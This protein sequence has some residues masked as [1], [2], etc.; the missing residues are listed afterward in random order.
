MSH[1]SVK[2]IA[3]N[4]RGQGHIQHFQNALF[5]QRASMSVLVS[6]ELTNN[7]IKYRNIINIVIRGEVTVVLLCDLVVKN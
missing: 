4:M 5:Q 6:S 2:L 3:D 1:I 7:L